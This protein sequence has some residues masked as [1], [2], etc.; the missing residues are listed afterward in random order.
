MGALGGKNNYIL[1]NLI[2]DHIVAVMLNDID[3]DDFN[4]SDWQIDEWGLHYLYGMGEWIPSKSVL[5]YGLI[6]LTAKKE[7]FVKFFVRY[8]AIFVD[9]PLRR[10]KLGTSSCPFI[11]RI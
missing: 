7:E 10:W 3:S 2:L 4:E 9:A 1:A 8:N 5:T 6:P 11:N